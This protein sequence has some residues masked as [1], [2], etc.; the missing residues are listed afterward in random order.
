MKR[1]G[2]T[3]G[4]SREMLPIRPEMGGDDTAYSRGTVD[5]EKLHRRLNINPMRAINVQASPA[6]ASILRCPFT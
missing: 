3:M 2:G 4:F 5:P 1:E 6:S